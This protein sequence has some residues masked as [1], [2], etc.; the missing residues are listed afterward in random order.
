MY[1]MPSGNHDVICP[2]CRRVMVA[3]AGYDRA[4]QTGGL[5]DNQDVFAV[6]GHRN[7]FVLFEAFNWVMDYFIDVRRGK[8]I[9]CLCRDILPHFPRSVICPACLFLLRRK[10]L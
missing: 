9:E 6:M 8:K 4:Q 5:T 1:N 3:L 10:N 2:E 7:P